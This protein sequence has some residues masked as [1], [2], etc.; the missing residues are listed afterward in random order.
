MIKPSLEKYDSPIVIINQVYEGEDWGVVANYV[1]KNYL[2]E[3]GDEIDLAE[4]GWHLSVTLPNLEDV[5]FDQVFGT[6]EAALEFG[7]N[8]IVGGNLAAVTPPEKEQKC[9]VY[10]FGRYKS[11][12]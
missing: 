7:I 9:E 4:I 6:A 12:A 10:P 5:D 8:Q 2:L 3:A 1:S 11:I